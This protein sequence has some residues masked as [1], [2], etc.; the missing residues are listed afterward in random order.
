MSTTYYVDYVNRLLI[1]YFEFNKTVF[2]KNINY[3]ILTIYVYY[4]NTIKLRH[5]GVYTH[6]NIKVE[7]WLL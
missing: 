7:R 3:V 2:T 4:L 6:G 5:V 1:L